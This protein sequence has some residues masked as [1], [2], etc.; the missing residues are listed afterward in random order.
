MKFPN[1]YILEGSNSTELKLS[2]NFFKDLQALGVDF[3]QV[4]FHQ[5]QANG[6][7]YTNGA[8]SQ[9]F[10]LN[11][12]PKSGACSVS[13]TSGVATLTYF[14]ISCT[15]WADSDGSIESYE[16]FC[17]FLLNYASNN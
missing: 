2:V 6:I 7:Y 16:L 1:E 4:Y 8:T 15:G 10:K 3:L 11:N 5:K 14:T 9:I 13:P 12:L 17:K